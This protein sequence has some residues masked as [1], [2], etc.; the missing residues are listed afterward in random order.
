ME[1]ASCVADVS[2]LQ[3]TLHIVAHIIHHKL[4]KSNCKFIF[5]KQRP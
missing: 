1:C 4:P 3:L 2:I 5:G